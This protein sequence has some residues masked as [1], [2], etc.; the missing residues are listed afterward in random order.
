MNQVGAVGRIAYPPR[1]LTKATATD[2]GALAG[3]FS[4]RS[5]ETIGLWLQRLPGLS[6]FCLHA[7]A[8][9]REHWGR[10]APTQLRAQ[11]A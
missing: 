5:L 4:E 8:N 7:A 10:N 3:H 2:S 6:Q 1:R 9:R 11:S